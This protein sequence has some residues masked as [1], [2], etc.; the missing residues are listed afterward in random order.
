MA[1]KVKYMG[2]YNYV[3]SVAAASVFAILFA[4]STFYH[5]YQLFRTRTWFF[6]AFVVGGYFE[7]IGY[8]A[9]AISGSQY[10]N[11][12]M[13]PIAIQTIL[14]LIAPSLF[15]ASVYMTL[16]RIIIITGGEKYA[17]VRRSWLTKIFV[18]GD[19][20]AFLT[21][22]GGAAILV[23]QTASSFKTGEK[24]IKVGLIFQI[25]FFGLFILTAVLFNIRLVKYG[26]IQLA[27]GDIPWKRHM[28]AL[29]TSSLFI[30]IRCI[31]RLVEY[32][33]GSTGFLLQHE[34]WVYI[35]DAA[36]MFMVMLVFHCIYPSEVNEILARYK[37][38]SSS[39]LPLRE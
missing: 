1:I 33:Q 9:R 20:I 16:G 38:I 11:Y 32:D 31:F 17:L 14:I 39:E 30:F 21:Q 27:A 19:I 2:E 35:F 10:P 36:L 25:I 34:Y 37:N 12:S 18:L 5:S 29:Y 13:A 24:V 22:A 15:A 23:Q 6:T 8:V 28:N 7:I 4:A 3:P 26:S